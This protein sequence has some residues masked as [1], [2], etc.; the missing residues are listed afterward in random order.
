[1]ESRGSIN[2]RSGVKCKG[3]DSTFQRVQGVH[4]SNYDDSE[5]FFTQCD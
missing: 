1:M 5:T 3:C 4:V 2:A